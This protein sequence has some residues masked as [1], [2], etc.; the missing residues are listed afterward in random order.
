VD[1]GLFFLTY[2]IFLTSDL[3]IFT[4]MMSEGD[5]KAPDQARL[6]L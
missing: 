6:R 3:P 5:R 4:G 1:A 2:P